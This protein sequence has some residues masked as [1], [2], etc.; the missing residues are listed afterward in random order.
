MDKNC[1]MTVAIAAPFT[2]RPRVK[3]KTGSNIILETAPINTDFIP[4]V[5]YPCAF[6]YGFIPVESMINIVPIR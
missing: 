6:M 5:E 1:E 4:L 3:I 2:P